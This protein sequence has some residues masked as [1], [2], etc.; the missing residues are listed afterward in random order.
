MSLSRYLSEVRADVESK[1]GRRRC[2]WETVTLGFKCFGVDK[3]G[4]QGLS[5]VPGLV[6]WS[7]HC[8]RAASPPRVMGHEPD[9]YRTRDSATKHVR[10]LKA[11]CHGL[12]LCTSLRSS[13][14]GAKSCM[15]CLLF[16]ASIQGVKDDPVPNC[17]KLSSTSEVVLGHWILPSLTD[18]S[19]FHLRVAALADRY[20]PSI[21]PLLQP[22][23]LALQLSMPARTT[24]TLQLLYTLLL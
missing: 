2:W 20:S 14:L 11:G 3:L 17:I 18:L 6:A 22:I 8:K 4:Q 12:T 1:R 21:S 10:P 23:L 19:C 7:V 9:A 13:L 16:C 5:V 15:Y 24:Y